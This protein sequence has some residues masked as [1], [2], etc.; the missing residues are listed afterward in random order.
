MSQPD[1]VMG[2]PA[3]EGVGAADSAE[4]A[5]P[6]LPPLPPPVSPPRLPHDDNVITLMS[7]RRQ[8]DGDEARWL[9]LLKPGEALGA[10][11]L[12]P[13]LS[14]TWWWHATPSATLHPSWLLLKVSKI[15]IIHAQTYYL[16]LF[17]FVLASSYM[18]IVQH[19][20]VLPGIGFYCNLK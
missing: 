14:A 7:V 20:Q 3:G 13:R 19:L 1:V 6:Q 15:M 18:C 4:A 8:Q 11:C 5:E 9:R 16:F 12:P 2:E 10:Q 17:K